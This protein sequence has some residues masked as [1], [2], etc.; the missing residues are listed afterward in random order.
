M[1]GQQDSYRI[2]YGRPKINNYHIN[3]IVSYMEII[4][5]PS[6]FSNGISYDLIATDYIDTC[7]RGMID[8]ITNSGIITEVSY[9]WLR[10]SLPNTYKD[11]DTGKKK[12]W[13]DVLETAYPFWEVIEKGYAI[14]N[15]KKQLTQ[16]QPLVSTEELLDYRFSVNWCSKDNTLIDLDKPIWRTKIDRDSLKNWLKFADNI[17]IKDSLTAQNL[18]DRTTDSNIVENNYHYGDYG[19]LYI[20]GPNN[21]QGMKKRVRE[22]AL[23]ECYRYDIKASVFSYMIWTIR[24][25]NRKPYLPYMIAVTEDAK[26]V[27]QT[28]AKDCLTITNASIEAKI[29]FVKKAITA[30]SFGLDVYNPWG[31]LSDIILQPD[32]R[33]RFIQHEIIQG[34]L[35]EIQ[36]YKIIIKHKYKQKE[37][38]NAIKFI[39]RKTLGHI[40]AYDYQS[41]EAQGIQTVIKE[42]GIDPLL[43]VHDCLYTK[44]PM[45]KD[46]SI[47]L[48]DIMGPYAKFEVK[49]IPVWVDRTT[50]DQTELDVEIH[51]QRIQQEEQQAYTQSI[52]NTLI[53]T[54]GNGDRWDDIYSAKQFWKGV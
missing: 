11:K 36:L 17:N 27:R 18:L 10:S 14:N 13:L 32:D 7:V 21:L 22:A 34:L 6:K 16:I 12:Y 43:I 4:S 41:T 24:G 40:C 39:P 51:K 52:S 29:Q 30:I 49:H 53:Q 45:P 42:T 25:N 37:Y 48:Q 38:K 23:G 15:N 31:K 35:A 28:L 46:A 47:Y 26:T 3:D 5:P 2:T 8:N 33:E 19:R 44:K 54:S 50:W 9:K 1:I 20:T